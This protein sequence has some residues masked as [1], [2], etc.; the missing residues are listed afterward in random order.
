MSDGNA[1]GEKRLKYGAVFVF[2]TG[3]LVGSLT[4]FWLW[5]VV[6][7]PDLIVPIL[8]FL[9]VLYKLW[10]FSAKDIFSEHKGKPH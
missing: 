2:G 9:G 8:I 6:K 7:N 3:I 10:F 5:F 1:L 4:A